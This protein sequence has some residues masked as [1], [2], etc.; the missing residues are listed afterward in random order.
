MAS[1]GTITVAVAV[2]LLPLILG[3]LLSFVTRRDGSASG[4]RG[5]T[6]TDGLRQPGFMPPNV[7]FSVV[8]PVLYLLLGVSAAVAG[9]GVPP[10]KAL[11]VYLAL[12]VNMIFNLSFILVQFGLRDLR[13]A[14]AATWGTF[15]TSA[16]LVLV[17]AAPPTNS[18]NLTATALGLV[19]PYVL[20]LAFAT[21]LSSAVR[22][23]NP[24]SVVDKTSRQRM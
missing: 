11:L 9:F 24:D 6:W 18:G 14:E 17:Y 1:A 20:W 5:E 21:V 16:V 8:W 15:L 12:A 3:T 13:L 22:R 23:L 7:V 4:Q 2:S 19:A 10:E